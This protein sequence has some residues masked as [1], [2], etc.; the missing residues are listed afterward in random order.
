MAKIECVIDPKSAIA[1]TQDGSRAYAAIDY[2]WIDTGYGAGFFPGHFVAA[3]DTATNAVIDWIDLGA[4]GADWTLQNK[5]AGL[6]VFPYT[7]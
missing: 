6:A 2:S 7:P 1:L 5:P 3:I 4:D